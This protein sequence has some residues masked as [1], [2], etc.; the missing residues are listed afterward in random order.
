MPVLSAVVWTALD[1]HPK[2]FTRTLQPCT[3]LHW[4]HELLCSRRQHA[5]HSA[6]TMRVSRAR[7]SIP[8]WD[9]DWAAPSSESYLGR[10]AK[11][12][13]SLYWDSQSMLGSQS[14]RTSLLTIS[15]APR[16]GSLSSGR[17]SFSSRPG[18]EV[19]QSARSFTRLGSSDT[20]TSV[21]SHDFLT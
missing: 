8:L 6:R 13:S 12:C 16:Y 2:H 1:E 10:P 14:T 17:V 19:G 20:S 15:H 9:R 11:A 3:L 5:I 18:Q 7:Y 4:V 21:S